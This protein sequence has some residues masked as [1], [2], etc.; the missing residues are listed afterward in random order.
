MRPSMETVSRVVN[1]TRPEPVVR[2]AS[3]LFP[4]A[5]LFSGGG[6]VIASLRNT[7]HTPEGE[8]DNTEQLLKLVRVVYEL[9]G[10][11]VRSRR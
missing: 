8:P 5:M 2:S 3:D 9:P 7:D 1:Q 10:G 11:D 6:K 4:R